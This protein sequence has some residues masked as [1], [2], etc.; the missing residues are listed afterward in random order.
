MRQQGGENHDSEQRFSVVP[1][2]NHSAYLSTLLD[3]EGITGL[4]TGLLGEAYQYWNS[5]GNYYVGDTLW[6]SDTAW[7]APIRFYK[8]TI[9]LDPMTR[10]TGALRVI[11]GS[12]RC[13]EGFA[14]QIHDQLN[15]PKGSWGGLDGSAIPAV[16]VPTQP[17]DLV[18]FDHATKHSAWGGN[19]KRRM[20]TIVFTDQ[21]A[22]K[23]LTHFQD[24]VSQ[25]GYTKREV[26]GENSGG[27]LLT[28]ATPERLYHLTQLLEHIPDATD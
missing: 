17:G 9:Y 20:L 2:I 26:F 12:H 16:A 19:L 25:H 1:C 4:A 21:H 22:G 15:R 5:D 13:G 14:E 10:D 3:D 24:V 6:H 8:M 11:P 7:P 27:P 18:V 28:T 23:A